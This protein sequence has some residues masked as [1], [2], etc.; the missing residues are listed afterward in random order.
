MSGPGKTSTPLRYLLGNPSRTP[1]PKREPKP[2]VEAPTM[3]SGLAP[4][5]QKEWKRITGEC[6]RLKLITTLD[7]ALLGQYIHEWEII[8]Q[9]LEQTKG[10]T[11][12]MNL[13]D[14]H[15]DRDKQVPLADKIEEFR[16]KMSQA[17]RKEFEAR[18]TPTPKCIEYKVPV[19]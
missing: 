11:M 18:L 4:R 16:G 1:Y 8:R 9:L 3:P 15:Y 5:A 6:V 14:L 10:R 17:E 19:Q 12:I 13:D 7:H 2:K